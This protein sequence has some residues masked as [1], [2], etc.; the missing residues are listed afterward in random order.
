MFQNFTGVSRS[1][2]QNLNVIFIPIKK[3]SIY[4]VKQKPPRRVYF[5]AHIML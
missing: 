2:N 4:I 3:C 1:N 5:K